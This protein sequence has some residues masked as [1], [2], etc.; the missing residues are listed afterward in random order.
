MTEREQLIVMLQ[1]HCV[2][3]V[4]R[5]TLKRRPGHRQLIEVSDGSGGIAIFEFSEAGELVAFG[6]EKEER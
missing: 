4:E 3:F 1:K 2:S 5:I 6:I